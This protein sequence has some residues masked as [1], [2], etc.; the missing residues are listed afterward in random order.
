MSWRSGAP[1]SK[2]SFIYTRTNSYSLMRPELRPRWRGSMA[3]RQDRGQDRHACPVCHLP[4]GRGSGSEGIVPANPAAD[5]RTAA[6]TCPSVG[7]E[8][9]DASSPRRECVRM[10]RDR[11]KSAERTSLGTPRPTETLGALRSPPV[12]SGEP[13]RLLSSAPFH[14]SS[15]E[16]QLARVCLMP[17][18]LDEPV[19]SIG[20]SVRQHELCMLEGTIV[21]P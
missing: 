14:S 19:Q 21:R 13:R 17:A 1:G 11:V 15:G 5:R 12:A 7:T 16:C 10:T 6:K 4:D 20:N 3:V 9:A 8:G 2:A 18:R